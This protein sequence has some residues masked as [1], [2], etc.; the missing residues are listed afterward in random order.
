MIKHH[1]ILLYLRHLFSLNTTSKA[2]N[3]PR[4]FWDRP[5]TRTS[6]LRGAPGPE[7]N[8]LS[9][10]LPVEETRYQD[11]PQVKAT[12]NAQFLQGRTYN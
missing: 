2:D 10:A 4:R 3:Q 1:R 12:I 11:R 9:N 5:W 7:I 8:P 6:P